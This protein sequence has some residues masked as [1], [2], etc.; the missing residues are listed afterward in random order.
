MPKLPEAL[1]APDQAVAAT[2]GLT[3]DAAQPYD[4]IESVLDGAS[5]LYSRFGQG[6]PPS[7]AASAATSRDD[8]YSVPYD[9]IAANNY[10]NTGNGPLDRMGPLAL[11]GLPQGVGQPRDA[12][13]LTVTRA[14]PP[15]TPVA[16]ASPSSPGISLVSQFQ[17]QTPVPVTDDGAGPVLDIHGNQMVR[18]TDVNPNFFV[19]AG[20]AAA[21]A[22]LDGTGVYAGLAAFIHGGPLDVQRVGPRAVYVDAFKDFANVAIGLYAA[23]AGIPQDATLFFANKYAALKSGF[24]A[25]QKMDP[26]YPNMTDYGVYDIKLGY[27]LYQSGLIGP[28][29][30]R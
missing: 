30:S 9:A 11:I 16:A 15:A 3:S 24:S 2:Q 21:A 19:D 26:T 20:L 12:G 28:S 7:L 4:A 23:A 14:A 22:D 29:Q 1:G 18:P 6:G 27:Q 8:L 13:N 5:S 10:P 25:K 17:S